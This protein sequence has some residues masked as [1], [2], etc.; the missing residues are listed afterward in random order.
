MHREEAAWG[1]RAFGEEASTSSPDPTAA[2]SDGRGRSFG[3]GE[4]LILWLFLESGCAS[5]AAV[6]EDD[7]TYSQPVDPEPI[8]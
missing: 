8:I 5:S 4:L 7:L 3:D 6:R 1:R 2:S